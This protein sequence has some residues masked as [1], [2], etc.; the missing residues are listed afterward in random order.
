MPGGVA[1][2]ASPA[3]VPCCRVTRL[4]RRRPRC[5]GALP[6]EIETLTEPNLP[7]RTVLSL[8]SS[9]LTARSGTPQNNPTEDLDILDAQAGER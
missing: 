2:G 8:E 3:N 5:R 7:K 6:T 4:E 1:I 9:P